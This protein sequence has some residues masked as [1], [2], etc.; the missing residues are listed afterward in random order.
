LIELIKFGGSLCRPESIHSAVS[1]LERQAQSHPIVVVCGG[2]AYA[3]AVR[4]EQKRLGLNDL[5]AHRQALLAMEQ[6]ALYIQEFWRLTTG[7]IIPISDS[8][9]AM[10]LWSPR[11][12]MFDQHAIPADWAITSDSLAAWLANQIHAQQLSL[13]KSLDIGYDQ[14]NPAEWRDKGWVDGAFCRMTQSAHYPIQL[15][16]KQIWG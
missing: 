4:S 15:V 8:G 14:G 3:D 6:T 11:K 2:G 7:R 10:T 5:V 12:I 16:G 1:W 13:M 9:A